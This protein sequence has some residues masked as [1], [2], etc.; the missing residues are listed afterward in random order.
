MLL[1]VHSGSRCYGEMLWR[2]VAAR[3]GNE[4]LPSDSPDGR[5]YLESHARL[6]EWAAFNRRLIG[7]ALGNLAACGTAEVLNAAHN[8][9]PP[10]GGERFIH[11]KGASAAEAAFSFSVSTDRA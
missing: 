3:H 2:A 11:R 4:G 10:C 1:L 7:S 6:I 5:A 8:S 9:I